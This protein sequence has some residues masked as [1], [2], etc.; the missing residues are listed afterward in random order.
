MATVQNASAY[1]MG[2]PRTTRIVGQLISRENHLP[3]PGLVIQAKLRGWGG[4]RD[5]G[6]GRADS[7]GRFKLQVQTPP[8][9]FGEAHT[10]FLDVVDSQGQIAGRSEGMVPQDGTTP[11][12][13]IVV[14]C[15]DVVGVSVQNPQRTVP[16]MQQPTRPQAGQPQPATHGP[17]TSPVNPWPIDDARHNLLLLGQELTL[18]EGHLGDE[19]RSCPSCITKHALAASALAQEG[20]KLAQGQQ[21]RGLWQATGQVVGQ[22]L[23]GPN[24]EQVRQLRQMVVQGI[25]GAQS[26]GSGPLAIRATGVNSRQGS[27]GL[28]GQFAAQIKQLAESPAIVA[29]A[30]RAAEKRLREIG[31]PHPMSP[32]GAPPTPR[33]THAS[34]IAPGTNC[35][36]E[37][38][39]A[40]TVIA[41]LQAMLEV[42]SG[43][44]DSYGVPLGFIDL[45]TMDFTQLLASCSSMSVSGT[46]DGGSG[47][48]GGTGPGPND[49]GGSCV[50]QGKG[51]PSPCKGGLD[52]VL[53]SGGGAC[54]GGCPCPKD[55]GACDKGTACDPATK[56]CK[57]V[58]PPGM[59]GCG[60]C[61]A[62]P[63]GKQCQ[64]KCYHQ[65]SSLEV[66]WDKDGNISKNWVA[67]EPKPVFS[68]GGNCTW[69]EYEQLKANLFQA[70][71][72]NEGKF[73]DLPWVFHVCE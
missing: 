62:C 63:E 26:G 73:I 1:P 32:G 38:V 30:A 69:E 49:P 22:T 41:V 18:L 6:Q 50:P 34:D 59:D 39:A 67:G 31:H 27:V 57:C 19:T 64:L 58:P 45:F 8:P 25:V 68:N 46:G 14:Q 51:N 37:Q 9:N 21:F 56:Q 7:H 61:E 42:A 43:V 13:Q 33:C 5:L 44:T 54:C 60:P 15:H 36:C 17:S 23:R 70:N 29:A 12:Q 71:I 53:S 2:Q 65:L 10:L 24:L 28:A 35:T 16:V 55:G 48:S 66:T 47:G 52:C 40:A 72:E 4:V 20:S 11:V 3:C